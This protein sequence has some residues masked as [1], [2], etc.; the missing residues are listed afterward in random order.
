[1]AVPF[2]GVKSTT[3]V[4]V[5]GAES[6]SVKSMKRTPFAIRNAPGETE[7]MGSIEKLP[8]MQNNK[9]LGLALLLTGQLARLIF[10]L[11]MRG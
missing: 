5:A 8:N 2:T 11:G 1:M 10:I 9:Q 6:V 7:R 4:S 3:T